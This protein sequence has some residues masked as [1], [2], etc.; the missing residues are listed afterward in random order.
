MI[1]FDNAPVCGNQQSIFILIPFDIGYWAAVWGN[2]MQ[3]QSGLHIPYFSR[4]VI[5]PSQNLAPV[6]IP[7]RVANP[8]LMEQGLQPLPAHRLPDFSCSVAAPGQNLALIS[9]PR[10]A[11]NPIFIRMGQGV[12]LLAASQRIAVPF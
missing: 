4:S 6:S 5:T 2:D 3:R 9:V 7:R 12:Q 1:D 10:C 11:V 8:T